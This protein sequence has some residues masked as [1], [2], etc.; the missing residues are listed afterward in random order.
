[1]ALPETFAPERTIG[2]SPPIRG[3]LLTALSVVLLFFGGLGTWA[4]LAPLESAAIAPG[5]VTVAGH[6]KTIQHFEGGIIDQLKVREGD[7]VEQ[8]QVI[9]T[10]DKTQTRARL[11]LLQGQFNTLLSSE[12]RLTAERDQ[13]DRLEFPPTLRDASADPDVDRLLRGET[14]LFNAR[15]TATASRVDILHK[16]IE[17]LQ[18]EIASLNAQVVSSATQLSLIHEERKAVATLVD[19]GVMAKPRLLELK[20]AAARLLGEKDQN[21]GLIARAKQRIG[22]TELQILDLYHQRM[23]EVVSDLRDVQARL[24]DVAE[25]LKAA[26][27]VLSRTEIRAPQAGVVVGLSVHTRGGVISP[28]QDLL[29]IVPRDDTLVVEAHI[30]PID[31]DVVHPGLRAQVR[32]TAF[33]QRTTPLL[34]GTL[35]RVSADSFSDEQTGQSYYLARVTI[36]AEEKAKLN[37]AELYPGMPAEVI[38]VTGKQTVIEYILAPLENSF[39]RA[40]REE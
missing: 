32:L 26:R 15:R 11:D 25:R 24:V 20:R 3:P 16:R 34:E 12:A 31:I 17:Q 36:S 14:A 9:I 39:R 8:S 37:G 19:K 18:N 40:F 10:L 33:K 23:N 2:D 1:M 35:I 5:Q 6:R 28:G 30:N 13:S 21:K 7:L 29:D 22:E 4:A 27:D 38:I